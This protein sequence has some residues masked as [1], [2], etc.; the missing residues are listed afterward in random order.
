MDLI[1]TL[2]VSPMPAP[3]ATAK[4]IQNVAIK[5]HSA[6]ENLSNPS[7]INP[8][9]IVAAAFAEYLLAHAAESALRP[10]VS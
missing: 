4:I 8:E 9:V 7:S 5:S 1:N 2:V 3:I 10:R 6:A